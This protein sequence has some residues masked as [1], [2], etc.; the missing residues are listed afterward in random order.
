MD[1]VN[2]HYGNKDCKAYPRLPRIAGARRHRRH[3]DRH[4][5][6]LAR[7]RRHGGR[8]TAR[9]TSTARSRW[10]APS[11]NSRPS[12]APSQKNNIIWQTGS[13][14]RSLPAISQG[15]GDR[16]QRPHRQRDARRSRIARRPPRFPQHRAGLLKKL[17][18]DLPDKITGPVAD[19]AGNAS[20]GSRRHAIRRRISTT[21][22]GSAL[23]RWSPTSKRA[24]IR[25]GAGT[26]TPA[27]DSCWTGSATTATSRTGAWASISPGRPKF[28]ATANSRPQRGLEYLQRN[29]GS[30]ATIAKKSPAIP[31]TFTDHRR[32]LSRHQHG[33]QMDRHR[34]LGLGRPQRLRCVQSRVGQDG[35]PARGSAQSEALRS[36]EHRRNFLDCVKSRKPTIAPVEVAHHSTIPG[37]LG[38]ISMLVGRKLHWDVKQEQSSTIRRPQL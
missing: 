1:T 16:S 20:V 17:S 10:P 33:N 9:R 27:A 34:R 14:Q 32:R 25:T 18:A 21:T 38:L 31:T 30:S 6:S 12:S 29:T 5:R 19:R 37:H 36:A 13:W 3:H 28:K 26:T 4:S 2:K 7:H 11:P 35:L 15:G 8:R 24:S 23:R 22:R